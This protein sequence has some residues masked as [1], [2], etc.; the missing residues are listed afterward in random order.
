M[1]LG[2]PLRVVTIPEEAPEKRAIPVPDWPTKKPEPV[3]APGWPVR[4]P[5]KKDA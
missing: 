2:K 3:K 4:D 1:D 5:A